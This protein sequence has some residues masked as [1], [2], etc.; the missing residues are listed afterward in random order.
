[1]PDDPL[2]PASGQQSD[3]RPTAGAP[4]WWGE[5][6]RPDLPLDGEAPPAPSEPAPAAHT[7]VPR[8]DAV[9]VA[10]RWRGW[11]FN[12]A[13]LAAAVLIICIGIGAISPRAVLTAAL[14][15]GVPLVLAALTATVVTRRSR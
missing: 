14:I 6:G 3:P 15:F 2:R 4:A 1:M 5:L 12:L 8:Q 11:A 13:V 7:N 10:R 9:R